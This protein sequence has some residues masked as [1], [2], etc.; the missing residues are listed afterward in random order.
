MECTCYRWPL[1]HSLLIPTPAVDETEQ[2]GTGIDG[3][4]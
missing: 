4:Y 2:C 3:R 1:C